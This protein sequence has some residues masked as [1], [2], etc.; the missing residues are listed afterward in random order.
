MQAATAT[1]AA[2]AANPAPATAA[3][4][5]AAAAGTTA[6]PVTNPSAPAA[7]AATAQP[8]GQQ[9]QGNAA[10]NY[11]MASLYVGDLA[12]DVTEAMLFEK[13]SSAGP[14]LSIRVCRDMITRR[15]LGYAYVN[16]QQPADGKSPKI[17]DF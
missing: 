17:Y 16:F 10:A 13:F 1:P 7:G 4:P 5:A 6:A 14:V 2:P 3:P 9:Q 11:P 15:S 12:H 8:G